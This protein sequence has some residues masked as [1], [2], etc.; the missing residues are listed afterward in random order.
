MFV[1]VGVGV[2]W[3]WLVLQAG[4]VGREQ[5]TVCFI[6]I[7]GYSAMAATMDQQKVSPAR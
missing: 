3:R 4:P 2:G 1:W 7:D 5:V 6:D